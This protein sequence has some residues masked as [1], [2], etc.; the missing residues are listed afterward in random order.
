MFYLNYHWKNLIPKEVVKEES[1]ISEEKE[2]I[3]TISESKIEPIVNK[4]ISLD[5]INNKWQEFID[6]INSERP[7]VGNVLSHCKIVQITGNRLEIKLVNGNEFN[8]RTL[9]N[10]KAVIEKYL[11]KIYSLSLK[12]VI[13]KSKL[14]ASNNEDDVKKIDDQK[15]YKT[16]AKLIELFDG[17]IIN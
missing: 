12:I 17:E 15:I 8:Y 2:K 14:K 10:N 7:S 16:T 13:L 11:E 6:D 3:N 9:E 1:I 4:N 5:G